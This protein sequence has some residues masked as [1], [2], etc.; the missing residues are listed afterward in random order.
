MYSSDPTPQEIQQAIV[1][2]RQVKAHL[3]ITDAS[4]RG[5]ISSSQPIQTMNEAPFSNLCFND[6]LTWDDVLGACFDLD[7]GVNLVMMCHGECRTISPVR[8]A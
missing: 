3:G 5:S 6:G 4:V 1:M 7:G 8:L 2:I